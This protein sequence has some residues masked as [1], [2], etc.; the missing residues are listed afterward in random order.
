MIISDTVHHIK[1]NLF[2]LCSNAHLHKLDW[3]VIQLASLL[4]SFIVEKKSQATD[5]SQKLPIR[6]TDMRFLGFKRRRGLYL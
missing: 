1:R 6:C 2:A 5:P 3:I 4:Y